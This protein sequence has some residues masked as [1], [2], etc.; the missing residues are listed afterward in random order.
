MALT[1]SDAEVWKLIVSAIAGAV[2]GIIAAVIAVGRLIFKLE[3]NV[4][5][6][7]TIRGIIFRDNG[8]LSVLTEKR[9][10]EMCIVNQELFGKDIDHIKEKVENLEEK[11]D[12]LISRDSRVPISDTD[13]RAIR[14]MLFTMNQHL[15]KIIRQEDEFQ[16]D[17]NGRNVNKKG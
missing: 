10:T 6:I 16:N 17:S 1:N 7:T 11:L 3:N 9:H 2:G 15:A 14:S 4:D 13:A 8:E 5:D 12:L